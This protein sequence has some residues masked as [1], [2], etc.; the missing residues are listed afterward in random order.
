MYL[1]IMSC[2]ARTSAPPISST[3]LRWCAAAAVAPNRHSANVGSPHDRRNAACIAVRRI[4]PLHR[5]EA[6]AAARHA[7]SLRQSCAPQVQMG[8]AVWS[9][10]I[11]P[12]GALRVA[13]HSARARAQS[14]SP[15]DMGAAL[16]GTG[17]AFV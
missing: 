7:A 5:P 10:A 12:I 9:D 16:P 17:L 13:S 8:S 1:Y 6:F 2:A 15:R 14:A 4:R 11:L 3:C